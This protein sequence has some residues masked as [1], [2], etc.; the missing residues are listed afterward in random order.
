MWTRECGPVKSSLFGWGNWDSQ[1]HSKQRGESGLGTR[2]CPAPKPTFFLCHLLG[3]LPRLP[4]NAKRSKGQTLRIPSNSETKFG[5]K[6]F[7][8]GTAMPPSTGRIWE[9]HLTHPE[10]DVYWAGGGLYK[11]Q[12][13]WLSLCNH[14]CHI[15][16]SRKLLLSYLCVIPL[17]KQ[18]KTTATVIIMKPVSPNCQKFWTAFTVLSVCST[19]SETRHPLSSDFS[20]VP[21]NYRS[22]SIGLLLTTPASPA[23]PHAVHSLLSLGPYPTVSSIIAPGTARYVALFACFLSQTHS[24]CTFQATCNI[25]GVWS[26]L[27]DEKWEWIYFIN[28]KHPQICSSIKC[29]YRNRCQA[30]KSQ[31]ILLSKFFL[32]Y[33]VW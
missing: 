3:S 26:F 2:L 24:S 1:S 11:G 10:N 17:S 25:V 5:E 22:D 33:E 14:A 4:P 20:V 21:I 31:V 9:W 23:I 12:W 32:E 15:S 16:G 19:S 8:S 27:R 18:N 29:T 6:S 7:L 28:L 30:P 13:N